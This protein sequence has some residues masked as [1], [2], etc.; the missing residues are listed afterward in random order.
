MVHK[1]GRIN[2][3]HVKGDTFGFLKLP[4]PPVMILIARFFSNCSIS[5][6]AFDDTVTF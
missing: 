6:N 4:K 1:L 5:R 3:A 2:F